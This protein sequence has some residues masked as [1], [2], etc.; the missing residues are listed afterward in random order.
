MIVTSPGGLNPDP[1]AGTTPGKHPS[2]G[3]S[4]IDG[5]NA[6]VILFNPTHR[7]LVPNNASYQ[8]YRTSSRP[9][10]RGLS[11]RVELTPN[12]GSTW[13]WRRVVF[14]VKTRVTPTA[15]VE[16][17]I[18]AQSTSSAT[19]FRQVRDLSGA[20][21]GDYQTTNAAMQDVLFEGIQGVDYLGPMSAKLDRTRVTVLKDVSRTI[22]SGNQVGRPRVVRDWT[23]V[24]KTLVYDDQENGLSMNPSPV[25]VNSKAGIGNIYVVDFISCPN[26]ANAV[27][28]GTAMTFNPASTL[29]WHER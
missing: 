22:S 23:S 6:H 24:N 7:W 18:G 20:I 16:A 12:D 28:N 1:A 25:S 29:Y 14:A 27:A 26:P 10:I 5:T 15:G 19:S 13:W 11:E 21:A 9:Y 4:T 3:Y 8:S 17:S 2:L